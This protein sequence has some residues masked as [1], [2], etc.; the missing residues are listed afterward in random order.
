M[1][2][3]TSPSLVC[4]KC[5]AGNRSGAKFCSQCGYP[6]PVCT[7]EESV[8]DLI[9]DSSTSEAGASVDDI[10]ANRT[11]AMLS[12]LGPLVFYGLAKINKSSYIRFHAIQSLN[13]FVCFIL[14]ILAKA[15]FVELIEFI[16]PSIANILNIPLT[17]VLFIFPCLG[18]YGFLAAR[19]GFEQPLPLIGK[20][21]LV[22]NLF[23]AEE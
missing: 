9:S 3:N 4:E 19:S 13:L 18:I 8:S 6:L 5:G 10:V 20:I 14:A 21:H 12:Y 22:N 23:S 17:I 7:Q 15:T 16:S 11:P 2:E 1:H